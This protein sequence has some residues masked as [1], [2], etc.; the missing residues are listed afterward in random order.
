MDFDTL[1]LHEKKPQGKVGIYDYSGTDA[2][3][4]KLLNNVVLRHQLIYLHS[5]CF[6][7]FATKIW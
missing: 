1:P 3:P 2:P 5:L 6:S 7:D 4:L